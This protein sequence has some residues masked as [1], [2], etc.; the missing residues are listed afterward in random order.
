MYIYIFSEI[1][2]ILGE[3][4]C[5][6]DASIVHIRWMRTKVA[7]KVLGHSMEMAKGKARVYNWINFVLIRIVVFISVLASISTSKK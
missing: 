1:I 5:E 6:Y 4:H 2:A 3:I 7:L